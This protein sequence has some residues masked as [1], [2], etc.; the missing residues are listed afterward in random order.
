VVTLMIKSV[1]DF[2]QR[3]LGIEPKAKAEPLEH[4]TVMFT[5][6]A[7]TEEADEFLSTGLDFDL[8]GQVDALIDSIYFAIGGLYKM[9]LTEKQIMECFFH[10][11]DANMQKQI[12]VHK[13]RDTGE[14]DAVK[15]DGW[16]SPEQH[17]TRVLQIED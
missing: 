17:F 9:G 6:R 3:V 7:L 10:V 1:I 8:P 12:G 11:H 13:K 15:P 4:Q 16:R 5:Y 14:V 2:N